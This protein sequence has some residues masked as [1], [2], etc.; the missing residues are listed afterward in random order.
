MVGIKAACIA[1]SIYSKLP[2]PIF[3]WKEKEMQYHLIFFPWVGAVIGGLL[4]LWYLLAGMLGVGHLAYTLV[5]VALPLLVTGGF[6]VDGFMDTMDAFCSY[7]SREEKLKIMKDPHIGAFALI[8]VAALGLCYIA[9]FSEIEAKLVPIFAAAFV[10]SRGLSGISVVS[11][12][13]AKS[14]GMLFTFASTAKA[15]PEK[16]VKVMLYLETFL[17]GC[18]MLWQE[19]LAGSITIGVMLLCFWYYWY[20][21]KKELGGITGDTAGFFVTIA[22]TG[23]AVALAVCSLAGR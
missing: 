10:F 20:R 21:S 3:D 19:L 9:A 1:F 16:F 17:C 13:S 2:V 18:F 5:G 8:S 7:Q 23:A 15:S 6:H 12:P 11:F 4:Y 14:E 22:E